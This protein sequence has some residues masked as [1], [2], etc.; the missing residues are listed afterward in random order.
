MRRMRTLI[1]TVAASGTLLCVGLLALSFVASLTVERWAR[2]AI[3]REVQSW[4][5][6]RWQSLEK[7]ALV[8][9]AE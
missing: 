7:P 9:A 4:V 6:A 3:E 1:L 2:L 5:E 8:R